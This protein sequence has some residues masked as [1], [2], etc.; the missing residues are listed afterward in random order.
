MGMV[1][2]EFFRVT[3]PW[4][5]TPVNLPPSLIWK[6][7]TLNPDLLDADDPD[8]PKAR[9]FIKLLKCSSP[10]SRLLN[11]PML[12]KGTNKRKLHKTSIIETLTDIR[13]QDIK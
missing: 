2:E 13:D 12:A 3:A 9:L 4:L 7:P 1:V 5:K 6:E 10:I 11:Q 8:Y